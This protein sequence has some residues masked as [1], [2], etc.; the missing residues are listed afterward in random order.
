MNEKTPE[1]EPARIVMVWQCGN[2]GVI[3]KSKADACKCCGGHEKSWCGGHEKSWLMSDGTIWDVQEPGVS[4]GHVSMP[5]KLFRTAVGSHAW[6]MNRED[7]DIDYYECYLAD[8]NDILLGKRFERGIQF[9]GGTR[10]ELGHIIAELKKG[11]LNH[12]LGVLSPMVFETGDE[13]NELQEIVRKTIS[14][15]CYHSIHGMTFNNYKRYFENSEKAVLGPPTGPLYKKK[16]YQI[17]RVIEFGIRILEGKGISFEPSIPDTQYDIHPMLKRLDNAWSSSPLPE[18]PDD[19][20]FDNFLIKIR[21]KY[22][23]GQ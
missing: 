9:D 18:T 5:M 11:N 13:H 12:I 15:N 16:L 4:I 20:V 14:K 1:K 23:K 19:M 17:G 21:F 10:Y 22:L 6:G 2:C 3:Y 8:I 7:S